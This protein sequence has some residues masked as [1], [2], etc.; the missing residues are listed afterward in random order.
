MAVFFAKEGAD[1]AIVYKPEEQSDADFVKERVEAEG[2]K[3]LMLPTDLGYENNCQW[4]IEQVGNHFGS[5]HILVN[6]A[7]EQHIVDHIED[8]SAEQMERTFKTNIFSMFHLTKHALNLM[9][10]GSKIINTTSIVAYRGQKQLLDYS[11]TKGAIVAFTRSLAAQLAP[12]RIR[13]NGVAPGPIWTPLIPTS[14]QGEQCAEWSK[15][16]EQEV[17]MQRLGQPSDCAGCYVFLASNE[18]SY[19][20]GQ[21]LHPNGGAIINT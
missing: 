1:V 6:N 7:A 18:S 5:L 9:P 15:E 4:V 19:I 14:F 13:V 21:V 20:S 3:C 11:A 17:F 10:P 2:R 16:N 12:R 8:L